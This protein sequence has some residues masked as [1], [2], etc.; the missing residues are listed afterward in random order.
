MMFQAGSTFLTI[1]LQSMRDPAATT[2]ADALFY[3][4]AAAT[5]LSTPFAA[6]AGWRL[7][8]HGTPEW[9]IKRI[10][11]VVLDSLI[12]AGSITK[13]FAAERKFRVYS[14]R[15]SDGS[16][17]CW[18]G[19]GTAEEQ[20]VFLHALEEVLSPISNP[21]YFLATK[22]V[23]AAFREDYFAVPEIIGRKKELA[24]AF[25]ARWNNSVGPVDLIFTHS[26]ENRTLLLRARAHALAARC[27]PVSERMSRWI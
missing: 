2:V 16:V 26:P 27:R 24:E 5:L 12:S 1:F 8:R 15:A 21:R 3:G 9:S 17:F 6:L 7:I 22:R 13:H 14:H 19:G 25:A 20:N 11:Q 4:A 23:L 10:G 18:L